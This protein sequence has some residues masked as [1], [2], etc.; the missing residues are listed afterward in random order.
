MRAT[1]CIIGAEGTVKLFPHS[2]FPRIG[3]RICSVQRSTVD[4]PPSM[5]ELVPRH[6]L[7]GKRIDPPRRILILTLKTRHTEDR[8]WLKYS[9]SYICLRWVD[10]NPNILVSNFTFFV[11]DGSALGAQVFGSQPKFHD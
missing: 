1:G 2:V 10:E 6:Y 8:V 5:A 9:S 3:F 11:G 7:S 4:V